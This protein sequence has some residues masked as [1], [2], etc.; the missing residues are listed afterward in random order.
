MHIDVAG[1]GVRS[2]PHGAG[3]GVGGGVQRA[4]ALAVGGVCRV[5]HRRVLYGL[6]GLVF[7]CLNLY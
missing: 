2:A 4:V 5:G 1:A 6:W 7:I 3:R